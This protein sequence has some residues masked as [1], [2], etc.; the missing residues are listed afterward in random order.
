M[1]DFSI[2]GNINSDL[3][4]LKNSH[5]TSEFIFII[6]LYFHTPFWDYIKHSVVR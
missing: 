4:K 2:N 6:K 1:I 3:L 5:P